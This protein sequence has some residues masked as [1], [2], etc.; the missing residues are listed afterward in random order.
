M[1]R[2]L[3]NELSGD[4]PPS[5]TRYP[6]VQAEA[7]Q[8]RLASA[9]IG[10]GSI[11][12]IQHRLIFTDQALGMLE[13]LNDVDV[14]HVWQE[15]AELCNDSQ[16]EQSA[17]WWRDAT[18]RLIKSRYP[19]KQY[20]YLIS[21]QR[22]ASQHIVIHDIYH[23]RE[24][25]GPQQSPKNERTILYQ[26]N[27]TLDA[28]PYRQAQ[29]AGV[30][31]GMEG[32]WSLDRK[33]V[34][35]IGTD[36]A[37]V[38]GMLNE[39]QKAAWLMGA[40]LDV[41]YPKAAMPAYTLVHNPTEGF[42]LDLLECWWDKRPEAAPSHNALHLASALR[43]RQAQGKPT[44][45]LVHSQGAIIFIR[46]LQQCR[47]QGIMLDKHQVVVHVGGANMVKLRDVAQA[48]GVKIIKNRANP[49]DAVPNLAGANNL[50]PSGLLRSISMFCSVVGGTP[51]TSPHSL[52]YLG[53]RS[54][55]QQLKNAGRPLKAAMVKQVYNLR[56]AKVK[57]S[58]KQL[59]NPIV[60]R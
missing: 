53:L 21:Y 1:Q 18:R 47:A 58:G 38:N 7:L 19:F 55:Q 2:I 10:K 20:H 42:L 33:D 25:K 51:L 22:E 44:Q 59:V 3:L 9:G 48:V 54:Y 11:L 35:T 34:Y 41:A 4:Y 36:Y 32:A 15:I 14:K 8:Q 49:F 12:P 5:I 43:Q 52:P 26:V 37:A 28:L 31:E 30:V 13:V 27:R 46:A 56:I 45:W 6:L 60:E 29:T 17:G 57:R 16:P 40:H 24:L 23:D 50:S 39:V